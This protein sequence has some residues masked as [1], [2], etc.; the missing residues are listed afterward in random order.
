MVG[1]ERFVAQ[2]DRLL[3]PSFET[4]LCAVV[5]GSGMGKTTLIAHWAAV[6]ERP[7]TGRFLYL[8]LNATSSKEPIEG[9]LTEILRKAGVPPALIEAAGPAGLEKLFRNESRGRHWVLIV[10]NAKTVEH[11]LKLLPGAG[12]V[13][14]VTSRV[15]LPGLADLCSDV[16]EL[17]PLVFADAKRLLAEVAGGSR[18]CERAEE[19]EALVRQCAGRPLALLLVGSLLKADAGLLL[20]DLTGALAGRG[21]GSPNGVDEALGPVIDLCYGRLD[22]NARQVFRSLG[23]W[24]LPPLPPGAVAALADLHPDAV[25]GAIDALR[26]LQLIRTDRF[27]RVDLHHLLRSY[28]ATLGQDREGARN[29]LLRWYEASAEAGGNALAADWAGEVEADKEGIHPLTFSADRPDRVLNWFEQELPTAVALLRDFGRDEPGSWRLALFFTPFLYL[30][31]PQAE[32][33]ELAQLG[34]G[35]ARSA[36]DELGEGRCLHMF[37]WVEHEVQQDEQAAHDLEEA[38]LL[39]VKN[40]DYR[41]LAWTDFGYGQSLAEEGR[42]ADSERAFRRALDHFRATGLPFGVAIVQATRAITLDK[43]GRHDAALRAGQEASYIGDELE[44]IPLR[45]LVRHQLGH[46]RYRNRD[47]R[48]A[49]DEFDSALPFRRRSGE[50]WGVAETRYRQGQAFAALGDHRNAAAALTE[51]LEI[52]EDLHDHRRAGWVRMA[53]AWLE[54]APRPPGDL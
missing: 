48:G 33:L 7:F 18:V 2:L 20:H 32:C 36:R 47:Y 23:A 9:L 41:G 3:E 22:A 4:R 8:D 15:P 44:N 16:I 52:F 10:E 30:R 17:E 51:S 42:F 35:I 6:A 11:V 13:L 39:Q 53:L 28:A 1:L 49:V 24:R 40:K 50:R 27:G 54:L 26:E 14:V 34:L 5:G 12:S 45:G 29:R 19:T 46:L 25:Q 38:R 37:A 31:K 21:K 43:A